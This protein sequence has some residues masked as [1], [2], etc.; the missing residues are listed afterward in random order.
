MTKPRRSVCADFRLV[1]LHPLIGYTL[2]AD[3]VIPFD[4]AGGVV[5]A[6]VRYLWMRIT[7]SVV[8]DEG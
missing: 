8:K 1:P 7:A 6:V 3:T 5:S 2:I 4:V